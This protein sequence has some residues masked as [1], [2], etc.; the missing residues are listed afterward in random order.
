MARA[1]LSHVNHSLMH[2][3]L[4]AV[5]NTL[6]RHASFSEQLVVVENIASATSGLSQ[7]FIAERITVQTF[8]EVPFRQD[9]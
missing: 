6:I 5:C 9:S 7:C 8:I 2:S 1:W 4:T 3:R